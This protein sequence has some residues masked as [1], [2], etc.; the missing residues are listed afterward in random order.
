MLKTIVALAALGL[1]TAAAPAP[2]RYDLRLKVA[3]GTA[4]LATPRLL[5]RAGEQARVAADDGKGVGWS[6]AM[7][8]TPG[9]QPGLADVAVA[10]D[11]AGRGRPGVLTSQRMT[12]TVAVRDP[13]TA[14]FDVPARAGAP[15]LLVDLALASTDRPP[16]RD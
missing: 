8:A 16:A 11:V 6:V 13:G 10:I 15:A 1:A 5:A 4:T 3:R 9:A 7:T 12:V 14:R 2:R